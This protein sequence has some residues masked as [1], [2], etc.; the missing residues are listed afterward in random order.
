MKGLTTQI[1]VD[2][3]LCYNTHMKRYSTPICVRQNFCR[4]ASLL[5]SRSHGIGVWRSG[6][7]LPQE[8]A[9]PYCLH[10]VRC[11]GQEVTTT[12]RSR[13]DLVLGESAAK[14][15]LGNFMII[16][17]RRLP[18]TLWHHGAPCRAEVKRG[19][20]PETF[21]NDHDATTNLDTLQARAD[22]TDHF[23]CNEMAALAAAPEGECLL[24]THVY[25]KH[26]LVSTEEKR[27]SP[28][29]DRRRCWKMTEM[30]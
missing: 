20:Q 19:P 26:G 5:H 16:L 1:G 30:E 7:P 13:A 17:P 15:R 2:V 24:P 3:V 14:A 9:T 4:S 8:H 18:S 25:L 21:R 29:I 10:P 22:L 11:F 28:Q 12:C 23:V 27:M 6:P